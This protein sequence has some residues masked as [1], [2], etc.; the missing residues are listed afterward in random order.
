MEKHDTILNR[1][2]EQLRLALLFH[3]TS[4]SSRSVPSFSRHSSILPPFTSQAF[5]HALHTLDVS[6]YFVPAGEA[7][8]ICFSIADQLGAYVLGLDSDFMILVSSLGA[9]NVKGYCPLDMLQWIDGAATNGTSKNGSE[10]DGKGEDG[11]WAQA[12]PRRGPQTAKPSSL[13]PPPQLI[14]PSLVLS[15]IAPNALRHRLRLPPSVLPLF[16][17]LIGNDYTPSSY[18][19][20][21]FEGGLTHVQKVEK[22]ARI[23]R[24][25]VFAP[26]NNIK[27]GTSDAGDQAVL[28]VKKVVNKLAFR[29]FISDT[30]LQEIVNVIIE[31]TFRYILPGIPNNPV[32]YPFDATQGH[33]QQEKA[34]AGYA[35]LQK[36][37][38]AQ[39]MTHVYL[40]PGR[41][42]LWPIL[43]DT[44]GPSLRAS[45][46]LREVRKATWSIIEEGC[47]G[48]CWPEPSDQEIKALQEDKDLQDL[49][50]VTKEIEAAMDASSEDETLVDG[51]DD[52][53]DEEAM[54]RLKAVRPRAVTEHV[55]QGSS[56]KV[57]ETVVPLPAPSPSGTPQCLLPIA[58]RLK[59]YLEILSSDTP[60]I[61]ALPP[62]LHPLLASTR[63]CV[64]ESASRS[65][66]TD[67]KWRRT[68]LLAVLKVALGMHSAWEKEG[69]VYRPRGQGNEASLPILYNRPAAIVAQINAIMIDQLVLAQSLL[70]LPE[71]HPNNTDGASAKGKEEVPKL[72]HLTPFVFF[73]GIG[74]HTVLN[75]GDPPASTG[76]RWTP[77]EEALLDKCA[78]AV[79][80]GIE[81]KVLGWNTASPRAAPPSPEERKGAKKV[82]KK[83]SVAGSKG[84][85]SRFDLLNGMTS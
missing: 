53:L 72:T 74:I 5:I 83:E 20:I 39:G 6:T 32:T 67:S 26:S 71:E 15:V 60:A 69:K 12:K 78:E 8:A 77:T 1:L 14:S 28:L 18:A 10:V 54:A 70:I 75:A 40:Y 16:A 66:K 4:V 38:M 31:S 42:Y 80:E 65:E 62:H 19:D 9:S 59:R 58:D 64:L 48:L 29:G 27:P 7:D 68:E 47:G 37:G 23:L 61:L 3:T 81:E 79:V 50:G 34:K 24:E 25:T 63:M 43:E 52:I 51:E 33:E 35:A 11:D 49:L 36:R 44:S 56:Q 2:R 85:G 55:R 84:M 73:S 30:E 22:V 21:F 82:A 76:W 41:L 46:G 45:E 57:I 13:L 17:S